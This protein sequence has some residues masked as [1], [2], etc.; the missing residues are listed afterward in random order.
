MPMIVKL[1]VPLIWDLILGHFL[2]N[3]PKMMIL[4][5]NKE[6]AGAYYVHSLLNHCNLLGLTAYMPLIM[7]WGVAKIRDLI[8]S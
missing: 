4:A 7:K 8:L 3:L 2:V 6:K 1:G 5:K